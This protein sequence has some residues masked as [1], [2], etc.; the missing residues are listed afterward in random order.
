MKK[1][2]LD[3][4]TASNDDLTDTGASKYSKAVTSWSPFALGVLTIVR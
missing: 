2:S 3:F 1:L 4:E